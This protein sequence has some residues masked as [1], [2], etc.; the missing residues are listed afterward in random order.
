VKREKRRRRPKFGDGDPEQVLYRPGPAQ[1]G[2]IVGIEGAEADHATRSLRLRSGDPVSITDG[3]GSRHHGVVHDIGKHRLEVAVR[4]T[5]TVPVWPRRPVW[6]GAGVI[7]TTRMDVLVEKASELGV[8][9]FTPLTLAR[10]VA[11]PEEGGAK[12]ERWGRIA[13]E[14][15]KQCKRAFL[16]EVGEPAALPDYLAAL[17]PDAR[18]VFADP[19]GV[20]PTQLTPDAK[21]LGAPGGG[22]PPPLV[23]VVGPEGG[24]EPME[25]ERLVEAGAVPVGLGSHRLRAETAG[26]VLVASVLAA[27]GEMSHV[28]DDPTTD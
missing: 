21:P 25:R 6:L 27:L 9:R 18:L 4:E 28:T 14:S 22:T 10:C 7:R 23:L 24:L 15:L 2:Q 20:G 11:V 17:P 8:T 12:F 1:P 19:G 13:V 16:M 3:A 26:V 5:E